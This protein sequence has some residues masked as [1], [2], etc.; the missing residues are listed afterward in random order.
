VQSL[1]KTPTPGRNSEELPSGWRRALH[2]A[3]HPPANPLAFIDVDG[4][5]RVLACA[6]ILVGAVCLFSPVSVWG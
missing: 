5:E 4:Q 1:P 2:F 3:F 6:A